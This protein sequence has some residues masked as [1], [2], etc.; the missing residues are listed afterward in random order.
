VE[1]RRFLAALATAAGVA[2]CSGG[3]GDGGD[4]P[5]STRSESSPSG[6]AGAADNAATSGLAAQ[7]IPS[8]ICSE[9]VQADPGIYAVDDPA[10]ASDWTGRDIAPEYRRDGRLPADETVVGLTADGGARAYPLSVL[11]IHESVN[12]AFGGPVLVTYCP[13]CRSGLVAERVVGGTPTTFGVSGLLWRPERIQAADSVADGRAFGA[14]GSA[15]ADAE[16][17]VNGN[18]VLYDRATRSYWSQILGRAICGPATGT[19]LSIR[20]STVTTWGEWRADHPETDVLLPPPYS[21]T[22]RPA[23][24]VAGRTPGPDR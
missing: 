15:G 21:E 2:G 12:D 19:G 20:P 18:L 11:T 6:A 9:P 24:D 1:R 23:D 16:V 22:F 5:T 8:T 17:G 14:S 3:S 10:F 4:A 13:L 7:G